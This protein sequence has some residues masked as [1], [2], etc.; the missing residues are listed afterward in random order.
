MAFTVK[1]KVPSAV[2]GPVSSPEELSVMPGGRLPLARVQEIGAMPLAE[3]SCP[4]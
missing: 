3:V 1:E 2:A 4:E